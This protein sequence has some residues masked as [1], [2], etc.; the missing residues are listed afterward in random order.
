MLSEVLSN[1]FKPYGELECADACSVEVFF[2]LAASIALPCLQQAQS[3]PEVARGNLKPGIRGRGVGEH[4]FL[5]T[6]KVADTT[7][8]SSLNVKYDHETP[9]VTSAFLRWPH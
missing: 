7:P 3:Q 9:E 2:P 1:R 6:Q 8:T 5:D 4:K